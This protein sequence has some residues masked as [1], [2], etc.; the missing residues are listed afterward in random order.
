MIFV[1]H[2]ALYQDAQ[3]PQDIVRDVV[4]NRTGVSKKRQDFETDRF[5]GVQDLGESF[6][7][8]EEAEQSEHFAG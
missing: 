3:K 7:L 8:I 2:L 6:N 4:C 1:Q 5:V